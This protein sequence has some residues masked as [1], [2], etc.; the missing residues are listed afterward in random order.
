MQYAHSLP[1][2]PHERWEPLATHLH[3]VGELAAAFATVFGWQA[4]AR[5]MGL[6]HDIGKTSD[7]YQRYIRE[8][9]ADGRKGPDHSTAGAR[10]AL[11]RSAIGLI[12][13]S[14]AP[15]DQPGRR[16][17]YPSLRSLPINNPGHV[18]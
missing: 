15:I 17:N 12:L 8:A 11:S 16:S 14:A 3:E 2:Q 1:G 9:R 13:P 6:L 18:A 5:V 10:E 4:T 7:A